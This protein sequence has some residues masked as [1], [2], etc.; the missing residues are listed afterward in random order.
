MNQ[1]ELIG[2]VFLLCFI[3]FLYALVTINPPED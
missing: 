2:L 1:G 3:V